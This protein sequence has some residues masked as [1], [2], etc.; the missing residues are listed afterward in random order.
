MHMKNLERYRTRLGM[1]RAPMQLRLRS[2]LHNFPGLWELCVLQEGAAKPAARPTQSGVCYYIHASVHE[3]SRRR[4]ANHRSCGRAHASPL[5]HAQG[6]AFACV[7][8]VRRM[9]SAARARHPM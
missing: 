3:R 4:K 7:Q 2:I 6:A 1:G 9:P 5:N 8:C